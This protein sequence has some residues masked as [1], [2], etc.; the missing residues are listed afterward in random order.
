MDFLTYFDKVASANGISK[1][2]DNYNNLYID[3]KARYSRVL[4]L[5]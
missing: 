2:D 1:E 4:V 5:N 3:A